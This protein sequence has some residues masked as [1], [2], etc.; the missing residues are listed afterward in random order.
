[1]GFVRKFFVQRNATHCGSA[2]QFFIPENASSARQANSHSIFFHDK[3]STALDQ[4]LDAIMNRGPG[5]YTGFLSRFQDLVPGTVYV[6]SAVVARVCKWMLV[7]TD[8][9][10]GL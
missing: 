3:N 2:T 10:T 5:Y 1:M 9:P 7:I 8:G 4:D 6:V